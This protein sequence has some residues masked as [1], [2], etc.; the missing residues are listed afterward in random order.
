MCKKL[1]FLISLV[2][3]LG[4]S[5][6]VSAQDL[7]VPWPDTYIVAGVEEYGEILVEGTLIVPAGATLIV[8]DRSTVDGDGTDGEGGSEYA[9]LIVDGGLF[10]MNDRLDLGADHDAYLIVQNGGSIV[11]TDEKIAIPDNDGGVHRLIV[12]DGTVDAEAIEVDDDSDRKSSVQIAC[13]PDEGVVQAYIKT[14]NTNSSKYDPDQWVTRDPNEGGLYDYPEG[15][16]G[17]SVLFINDLGGNVKEVY[18]VKIGPKAWNPGPEDGATH[19]AAVDCDMVLEWDEGN[20]LALGA[21]LGVNVLYFSTDC[22]LVETQPTLPDAGWNDQPAYIG[23]FINRCDCR[24]SYNVGTL[25]LW[26]TYCWRVDQGCGDGSSVKGDVW[27]FTTGC[28][29]EGDTNADCLVNFLDYAAVAS[30]W[31][32]EQFFPEGCTP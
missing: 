27:T 22:D 25:P 5:L 14:G 30:T 12:I 2:C 9:Q 3:L 15:G 20:C 29:Q 28:D 19:E 23:S 17:G 13:S 8:N 11:H 10:I 26:T 6:P 7:T 24:Q 18:Y 16:C 31:M 32:G 1:M 21:G 4:L